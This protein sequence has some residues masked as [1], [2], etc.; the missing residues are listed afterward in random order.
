MKNGTEMT[1]NKKLRYPAVPLLNID[2]YFNMWSFS[3]CLTDDITRHWTGAR[4]AMVGMIKYEGKVFRFMGK[5]AESSRFYFCE[6]DII[7]QTNLCVM[8]T[9][10][11]Y[12]FEND[13]L[14][15][16][17]TFVSPVI[18]DDLFL[19][20]RPAA[21][22]EYSVSPKREMNPPQV[23]FDISCECAVD[24]PK[25]SV[26][27]KRD[28]YGMYCGNAEQ[29]ILGKC[30]DDVRIDWGYLHLLDKDGYFASSLQ[31]RDAFANEKDVNYLEEDKSYNIYEETPVMAVVKIG[32]DN[33]ITIA[34]DDIRSIRYFGKDIDAYYKSNGDSFADICEKALSQYDEVKKK[35]EVFDIEQIETAQK[36]S[37]E[38]ADIICGV[39]RQAIASHKLCYDENGLLFISKECFSNGCGATLDIT[40]PSMPLFMCINPELIK[41]MLRPIFDFAK[42]DK[43]KFDFA[44]HDCGTY[45]HLEG[46][47]YGLDEESGELK[48]DMQMPVEESGN[49]LLCTY[50]VCRMSEDYTYATENKDLLDKWASYL[51]NYGYDPNEQICTDDFA[52]RLAH[53]CNLSVKAILGLYAYGEMFKNEE[54]KEKAREFAKIWQKEAF[55][56]DHY[57]LAFDKENSWSLKYNLVWDR[58]FGFNV[59]DKSVYETEAKYYLTQLGRYGVK[60]DSRD[61]MAKN[62][63]IM[64][65]SVLSRDKEYRD[66]LI[67]S[68]WNMMNETKDRVPL[69]DWYHIDTGRQWPL[70]FNKRPMG[71][72]NR[73]VVGGFWMPMLEEKIK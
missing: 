41:G 47:V 71:F 72:S 3:D 52:G 14:V 2:P 28:K 27:L 55:E 59:F 19:M 10:T 31:S 16:T 39:Y 58:L 21:Y 40:Y 45:P 1:S 22:V 12:T 46:Q 18:A 5:C 44:P 34:Y 30:G 17:V 8:P 65:A 36:I 50:A 62:D 23:Y 43:W 54:Y 20:S 9:R 32:F 68:V 60:L 61:Y 38:Y 15:L 66:L 29:D 6:P 49:M 70:Y 33:V 7:P 13:D 25:Q 4:N 63:W 51:I 26:I 35:C 64:W 57:R 24:D 48:Y 11:I 67:H 73:P 37:G 69:G 42:T 53:N 56:G